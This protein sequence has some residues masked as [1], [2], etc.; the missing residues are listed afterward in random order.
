[1]LL[2][3]LIVKESEI[4]NMAFFRVIQQDYNDLKIGG[5]EIEAKK[6]MDDEEDHELIG[7]SEEAENEFSL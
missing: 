1:M 5:N 7:T 6:D 3:G 2:Y 4:D